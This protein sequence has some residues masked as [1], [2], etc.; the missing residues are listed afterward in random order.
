MFKALFRSSLN[1]LIRQG[2]RL[3]PFPCKRL[4][5]EKALRHTLQQ[6]QEYGDLDFMQ[7]RYLGI[8]VEEIE[9]RLVLSLVN[10]SKG[11]RL[12]LCLR[13]EADAW[14]KGSPVAFIKMVTR[15]EDPDTL[16]FQ[17]KLVIEGDTELGLAVKNMLDSLDT[18]AWPAPVQQGLA[19]GERL[20]S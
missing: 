11:S 15:Q 1:N 13:E 9:L 6:A 4:I 12:C 7:G 2:D 20:Y 19:L 5:V 10:S 14:I 17:R 3:T 16:F 18:P 8:A